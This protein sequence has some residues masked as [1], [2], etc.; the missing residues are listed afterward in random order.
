MTQPDLI[1]SKDG[2]PTSYQSTS[3]PLL[4]LRSQTGILVDESCGLVQSWAALSLRGSDTSSTSVELP[5][6]VKKSK[7]LTHRRTEESFFVV[8]FFQTHYPL[9]INLCFSN[10]N[11]DS[12]RNLMSTER[13][14]K[15]WDHFNSKTQSQTISRLAVKAIILFQ[16][17]RLCACKLIHFHSSFNRPDSLWIM[18]E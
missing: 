9:P 5:K 8:F 13:M 2:K 12:T 11:Y 17:N 6:D 14:V 18:I 10:S 1:Q 4:H 7:A 3:L 15:G 16:E